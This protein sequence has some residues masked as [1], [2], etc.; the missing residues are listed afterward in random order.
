MTQISETAEI[1]GKMSKKYQ[2]PIFCSFM[3]G[4]AI[5]A[6]EE[7]LNKFK[8]PSFRYPERAIRVMGK[9]WWWHARQIEQ[10][11]KKKRIGAAEPTANSLKQSQSF[12]QRLR[13]SGETALSNFEANSLL[14]EWNITMPA[15]KAV[16]S[17][18]EA[19]QFADTYGWPVV[20]KIS[21]SAILH[22]TESH[23]VIKDLATEEELSH[24]FKQLSVILNKF[25][26]IT[27]NSIIEAQQQ[28]PDG[29][30]VIVGIKH[31]P[32]FGNVLLFGAGGTMAELIEDHNLCVAPFSRQ[33][34]AD[35]VSHSKINKIL[36][37]YRGGAVYN[38]EALVGVIQRLAQLAESTDAFEEIEI[39]PVI[40]TIDAAY[41]VDG[42]AIL[43]K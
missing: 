25:K 10:K 31:D 37:G 12:I 28:I 13:E 32:S 23:A 35:L 3:G 16:A 5:T 9:M 41:A 18:E 33:T 4:Q 11:K 17:E 19:K 6:G 39:N 27:P 24:A 36:V 14:A 26:L 40:V 42:R 22:K 2:K 8:I 43:K 34:I 1:I 30:E 20:L 21:S 38:T 29:V 15:L 7:I